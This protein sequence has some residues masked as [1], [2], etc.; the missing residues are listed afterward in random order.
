MATSATTGNGTTFWLHDGTA[1]VKL[2]EIYDVPEMP[3]ST[4]ELIMAT[5]MES[6]DFEDYIPAPHRDGTEVTLMMNFVPNSATDTLCQA[7]YDA[8]DVRAYELRY[9]LANGSFRKKT[10]TCIVRNYTVD[11]PMKDRRSGRLTVKWMDKPTDSA[12]A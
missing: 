3:T 5:H 4:R 11:N 2:G 1:L 7:A 9:R 10:G 8:H 6:G 12:V